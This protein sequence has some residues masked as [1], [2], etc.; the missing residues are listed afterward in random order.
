[1]KGLLL[2][3]RAR[4]GV[5]RGVGS[6]VGWGEGEGGGKASRFFPRWQ[7]LLLAAAQVDAL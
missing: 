5:T 4:A 3:D 2:G 1:M 7:P 6:R